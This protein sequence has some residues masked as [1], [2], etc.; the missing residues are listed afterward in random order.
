MQLSQELEAGH[1]RQLILQQDAIR[2][3]RA[4]GFQALGGFR[5]LE[6]LEARTVYLFEKSPEQRPFLPPNRPP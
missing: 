2:R 4:A 1:I 6:K 3:D 5:F